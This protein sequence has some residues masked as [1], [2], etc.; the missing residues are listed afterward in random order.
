[1]PYFFEVM[2]GRANKGTAA[3]AVCQHCGIS[4][5]HLYAMG[6]NYNDKE[7]LACAHR[8]FAPSNAV[9]E[10]LAMAHHVLPHHDVGA[11]P[12]AIDI[13]EKLY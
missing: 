5:Q 6:D 10:I 1:M 12:A 3:L 13:L 8:A 11:L 2:M 4:P 9:P 7:L